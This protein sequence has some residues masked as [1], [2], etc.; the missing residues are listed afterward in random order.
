[1]GNKN[2]EELLICH[3]NMMIDSLNDA[4]NVS[5]GYHT[6]D[7]LYYHRAVLFSVICKLFKDLSWK[8]KKHHDGSMYDKNFIVGINTP[9][10]QYTY[11]YSLDLWYMFDVKELD[12]APEYDGH[13]PSDVIRLFSLFKMDWRLYL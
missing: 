3:I 4:G 11:H 7:E 2:N 5:D 1:M 12:N 13:S 9:M 8:S 6:F 10:G